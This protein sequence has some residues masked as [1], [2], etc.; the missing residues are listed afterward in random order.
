MYIDG[1]SRIAAA[2]FAA[3]RIVIAMLFALSIAGAQELRVEKTDRI[4]RRIENEYFIADLSH[5]TI[6]GREE[7]S[8]TLRALTYKPFNV[9]LLRT[10][11][12]MHWAPNM[13]REG[14]SS[15]KGIGSWDPVQEF[16]EEEKS[17]LYVHWRRGFLTDYPEVKIEAEY[18]FYSN[19]PYF[20]VWTR[21]TVDK[22]LTVT[23]LRNNEMTMDQF[24]THLAW[25][26]PAGKPYVTTFDDRHP[27]IEKE[28]IAWDAPW[29]VFL[30]LEKGYGYGFVNLECKATR[31]VH[32]K[33][34]I[35]DGAE[36]GKYWSRY[37]VG[38]TPTTLAVGDQFDERTAYVLFRCSKEKPLEEF[39]EWEKKIRRRFR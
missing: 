10:Q 39:F 28:P 23:L 32:P 3:A 8:G 38:Q 26:S 35:S 17:D 19:D 25:P 30:N 31:T 36:N 5:R 22:P 12:R 13:Q 18:R 16:R 4:G 34:N 37:L 27:I 21:M 24:F 14:A 9:T 7:D 15:Y 33:I 6:R 2:R 11:N 20:V 29:V 1:M